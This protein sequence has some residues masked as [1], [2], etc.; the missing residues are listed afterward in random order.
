MLFQISYEFLGHQIANKMKILKLSNKAN[1][2]PNK[3][4]QIRQIFTIIR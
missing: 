1:D 4:N 2:L 3:K